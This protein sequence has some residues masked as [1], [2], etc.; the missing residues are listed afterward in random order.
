MCNAIELNTKYCLLCC[1]LKL[2]FVSIIVVSSF[3]YRLL[4]IDR[5]FG[6]SYLQTFART[7]YTRTILYPGNSEKPLIRDIL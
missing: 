6:K 5:I 2:K 1:I 3:K 4:S 7:P